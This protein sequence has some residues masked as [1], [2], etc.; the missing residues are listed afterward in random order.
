MSVYQWELAVT[1][2]TDP[3]QE[4]NLGQKRTAFGLRP[5]KALGAIATA[6]A[7]LFSLMA[8]T[9]SASFPALP[10]RNYKNVCS[11]WGPLNKP[12]LQICGDVKGRTITATCN[13]QGKEAGEATITTRIKPFNSGFGEK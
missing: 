5:V 8:C 6:I 9:P 13:I 12:S 7:L 10:T 11:D 2:D 4:S 1:S 3:G